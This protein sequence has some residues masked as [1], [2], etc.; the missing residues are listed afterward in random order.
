MFSQIDIML[1]YHQIRVK[2]KDIPKTTFR[3]RYEHYEYV[4]ITFEVTE[5]PTVF[6]D[7]M[8]WILR[9]FLDIFLVIFID[10]ILIYSRT[11]E[12]HEENLRL[13]VQ[14]LRF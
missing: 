14:N 9:S 5:A 7:Y 10:D 6:M 1:G 12:D 2:N 3:T 8:N 4:L 11:P 13:A